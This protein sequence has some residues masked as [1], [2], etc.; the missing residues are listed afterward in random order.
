[1]P[2]QTF[3]EVDQIADRLEALLVQATEAVRRGDGDA[4]LLLSKEALD[5]ALKLPTRDAALSKLPKLRHR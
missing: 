4:A 1:M 3:A 2:K 5:T